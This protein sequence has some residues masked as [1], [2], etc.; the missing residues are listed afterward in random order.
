MDINILDATTQLID[1][2]SITR[3]FGLEVNSLLTII[4]GSLIV[5]YTCLTFK[6]KIYDNNQRWTN[7]DHFE[8]AMVS[9]VIGFLSILASL[10]I[11]TI[12]QFTLINSKDLEQFFLQ[13]KYVSP[14][15]YF[16][17]FSII[18]AK[19]NY[20]ELDFIKKYI[21]VSF[22]LIFSLNFLLVLIILYVVRSWSGIFWIIIL[23]LI[24]LA[25]F[26]WREWLKYSSQRNDKNKTQN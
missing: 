7:L 1:I 11:V 4:L 9:M 23:I 6:Y 5:G 21:W 12:Y 22:S 16:I 15:L 18:T 26:I 8:K 20:E 24:I 10:Y 25:P 3:V 17:S 19:S 14:F 13:L 2:F